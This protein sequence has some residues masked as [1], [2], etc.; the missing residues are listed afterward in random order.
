MARPRKTVHDL[1]L[2]GTFNRDSSRKNWN[3]R[4]DRPLVA[5]PAPAHYLKRTQIA[6]NQFMDVKAAQGVLSADDESCIVMMFDALDR[7]YRNTDLYNE[8]RR[9]HPDYATYLLD[10]FNRDMVKHIRKEISEDDA[11]FRN[12]AIRFGLTPTERTKLQ[13]SADN[14]KSEMFELLSSAERKEG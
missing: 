3:T 7:L 5:K 4:N 6:W 8:I 13:I 10:K 14:S 12:W 2:S 11:T 1:K 9:S